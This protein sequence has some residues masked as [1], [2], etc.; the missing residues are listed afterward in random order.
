MTHIVRQNL[1]KEASR[2]TFFILGSRIVLSRSH[3]H[4]IYLYFTNLL[5][6]TAIK[7]TLLDHQTLLLT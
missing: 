5:F 6:H 2:F 3:F 4:P 1:S 7:S